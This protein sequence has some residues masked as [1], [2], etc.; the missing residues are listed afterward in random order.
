MDRFDEI[1]NEYEQLANLPTNADAK[2]KRGRGFAFERPLNKLDELE[3]CMGF[4][5]VGEQIDRSFYLDGRAYLIETNGLPALYRDS[6]A[7]LR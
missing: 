4:R 1:R 3:P 2:G 7:Y 6:W 5:L